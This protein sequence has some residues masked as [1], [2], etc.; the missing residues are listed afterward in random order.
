[1]LGASHK[2]TKP[3]GI[4]TWSEM[5]THYEAEVCG[6]IPQPVTRIQAIHPQPKIISRDWLTTACTA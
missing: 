1:M 4:L 5:T 2:R 3:E 6:D